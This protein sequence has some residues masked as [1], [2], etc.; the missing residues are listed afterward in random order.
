MYIAHNFLILFERFIKESSTGKR[1]AKNGKRIKPQTIRNYVMA[2][3]LLKDFIDKTS[4]D[5]KLYETKRLN[6]RDRYFLSKYWK[7]FYS[8][9]IHFLYTKRGCFDNYVGQ[10]IKQI[11]TFFSWLNTDKSIDT[12]P[13]YRNFYVYHEEIPILT[14][15]IDRL[16]YLLHDTAFAQRL[17]IAQRLTKDIFI[18]GSMVGLRFG[19]LIKLKKSNLEFRDG[20]TYL[21]ARAQKTGIDTFVKLPDFAVE[22]IRRYQQRAN[23]FPPISLFYF[24]R[25]LKKIGELA[26]W[27]ETVHRFRCQRGELKN[28]SAAK[29]NLKFF[30]LMSSHL[31][32]RTSITNMLLAGMPEYVVRKVSG[33]TSDSRAFYR[34]VNLA[35][36]I[37]DTEID[38]LHEKISDNAQLKAS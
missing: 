26:Q 27:T 23:L 7:K 15:S 19:D 24:N 11:K 12:G 21:K 4:F 6:K 34:Y 10:T 37:M 14:L 20:V 28:N 3:N 29:N 13:Y 25:C 16:Q 30:E 36:S 8:Q 9:F 38:K 35:Q 17:T 1:L 22:I 33:H 5:L 2:S 31:M 18:L 32:R